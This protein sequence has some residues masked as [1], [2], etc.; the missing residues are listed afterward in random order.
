[1]TEEIYEKLARHLDRLPAGFPRTELGV[2]LRILKRLFDPEEAELACRLQMMPEPA[3]A[4][5]ARIGIPEAELAEKLETMSRKGLILRADRP[6]GPLYMAAQY[7]I[8]IWEYHVN[9]LDD[10]IGPGHE[11]V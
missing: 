2:E 5:A 7:V 6:E 8:G 1:M 4:V 3:A 9:D 11:R 10:R